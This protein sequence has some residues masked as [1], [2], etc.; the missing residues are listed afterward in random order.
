VILSNEAKINLV[1]IPVSDLKS[2][3]LDSLIS[4]F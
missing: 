2:Y 1:Q 4:Q 3:Q